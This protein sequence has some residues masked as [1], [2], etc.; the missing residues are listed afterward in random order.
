MNIQFFCPFSELGAVEDEIFRNRQQNE[1]SSHSHLWV[2]PC[3]F[4]HALNA[5]S[6]SR[7]LILIFYVVA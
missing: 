1:V 7:W 6:V 4:G 3:H 5:Q 2:G